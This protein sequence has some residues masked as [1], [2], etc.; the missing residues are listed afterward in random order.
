MIEDLLKNPRV[1]RF[2][3]PVAALVCITLFVN[4]GLW[5]LDRAAEKSALLEQ[6]AT[7][8]AYTEPS[9]FS[10]LQDF[11][12]IEVFGQYLPD[13]QVLIDNIPRDGRIGF[14]V[15]TPFQPSRNDPLLLVNRGWL[16]KSGVA[17]PLPALTVDEEFR[18]VQGFAGH[19]PRVA[20][21][22]GEA[23]AEHGDWPR[24]A[25]YPTLQEISVE[26]DATLL[27]VIMLLGP[28]ASDGFVR[29][30]EPDISGPMTHYSYAFQWFSMAVAVGI[31]LAWNMRKRLSRDKST[32]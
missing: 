9:D 27:P 15:I 1:L 20:I 8:A 12:R 11:D 10:S 2:V 17:E 26:L 24:V 16:P 4:L 5:Q 7:D 23:F 25:L 18:T 14:Y 3:P 32:P 31:I 21:R 28:G 19:L 29:R 30:W 6:F 22:P 13:R